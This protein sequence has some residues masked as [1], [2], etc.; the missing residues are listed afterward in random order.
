MRRL[1]FLGFSTW[2]LSMRVLH[3]AESAK[4]GVGSYLAYCV[5]DQIAALGK[6]NVRVLA[7]AQ[8]R[9]QIG[10]VPEG[11]LHAYDRPDRSLRALKTLAFCLLSEVRAFQ[12]DVIHAHSTVAGFV[13]RALFA[14]VPY[15]P[16]IVYCPH[17]WAF[18]VEAASW[19]QRAMAA[20]ERR[21]ARWSDCVVAI[22]EHEASEAHRIGVEARHVRLIV[23]GI[24]ES[25]AP[26]PQPWDD[27]RLKVLFIGRLDRQKGFDVL[28]DAVR[29]LGERVCVRVAGA[30]VADS[31]AIVPTANVEMLGWLDPPRIAGQIAAADVVAVPS[32]WEGFGLAAAEAMRAGK[33]VIGSRVGGLCEL[34]EDGV[35]GRLA[36]AGSAAELARALLRD[37]AERHRAMGASGR[38]RYHRLFSADRMNE[39]LLDLYAQLRRGHGAPAPAAMSIAPLLRQV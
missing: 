22:S 16:S 31:V 17:G 37:N 1:Q 25:C 30:Q 28:V 35:T 6:Q 36:E 18:N 2:V 34:V 7:P 38:R 12:P 26:Q 4:G 13:T 10:P 32:R 5:P 11:V 24:P 8:H 21:M 20:C 27:P 14:A 33:P 39:Q 3:V 29:A 19:K 15:R 9:D 23:N